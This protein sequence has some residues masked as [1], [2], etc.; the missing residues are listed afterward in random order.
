MGEHRSTPGEP[1]RHAEGWGEYLK[2]DDE[3]QAYAGALRDEEVIGL[4]IRGLRKPS[5]KGSG[6]NLPTPSGTAADARRVITRAAIASGRRP[7]R[8]RPK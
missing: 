6:D 8:S 4:G 3:F 1:R 5:R 2:G 7:S